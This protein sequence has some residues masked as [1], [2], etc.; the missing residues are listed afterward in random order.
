MLAQR[1]EAR[2]S[3][4]SQLHPAVVHMVG[5]GENQTTLGTS[6]VVKDDAPRE[7][8]QPAFSQG[9]ILYAGRFSAMTQRAP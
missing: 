6:A 2:G 8:Q 9:R 3:R 4:V 1:G 7:R 5:Q